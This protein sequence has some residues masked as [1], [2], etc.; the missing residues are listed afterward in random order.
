MSNVMSLLLQFYYILTLDLCYTIKVI[1]NL[2]SLESEMR[3]WSVLVDLILGSAAD[4]WNT[5]AEFETKEEAENLFNSVTKEI[6]FQNCGLVIVR[7]VCIVGPGSNLYHP[8]AIR[9]I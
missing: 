1:K 9:K 3:T 8:Y 2:V 7:R 6:Y 4:S 5:L